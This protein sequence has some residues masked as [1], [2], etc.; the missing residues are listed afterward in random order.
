MSKFLDTARRLEQLADDYKLTALSIK[1]ANGELVEIMVGVSTRLQQEQRRNEEHARELKATIADTVNRSAIVRKMA[2]GE[3]ERL[4]AEA[5]VITPE[6]RLMFVDKLNEANA[7]LADMRKIEKQLTT[8]RAELK[9]QLDADFQ[10][11]RI[12]PLDALIL[13][14]NIEDKREEFE[15]RF[16]KQV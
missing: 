7:A 16:G 13:S 1:A 3:L 12:S 15:R 6:E 2:Q 10:L 8:T 5:Q 9:R 14:R 11:S 4:E